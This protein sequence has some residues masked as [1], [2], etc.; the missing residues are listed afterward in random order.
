[1]FGFHDGAA[2]WVG[3]NCTIFQG[4]SKYVFLRLFG[5]AAASA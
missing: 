2:G 4:I 5:G 1:L 3:G